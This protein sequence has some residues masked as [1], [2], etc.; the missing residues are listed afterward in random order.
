MEAPR[1][2]EFTESERGIIIS[3]TELLIQRNNI[4]IEDQFGTNNPKFF[5]P[6]NLAHEL[7]KLGISDLGEAHL[8]H[9]VGQVE[10]N[11]ER[12][13]TLSKLSK[14][15]K[16]ILEEG[17][18]AHWNEPIHRAWHRSEP[19]SFDIR[20]ILVDF[21]HADK[22]DVSRSY[23]L[24]QR[25]DQRKRLAKPRAAISRAISRLTKRGFL[26]SDTAKMTAGGIPF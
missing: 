2:G 16:R 11:G 10:F 17:L 22:E 13:L 6:P 5:A 9:E 21:F 4:F 12:C 7:Q 19:G 14:L 8:C 1:L 25:G 23:W 20:L 15:Q 26:K 24:R 18:R 3:T